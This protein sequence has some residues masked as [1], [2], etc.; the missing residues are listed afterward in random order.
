MICLIISIT[1]ILNTHNYALVIFICL[2]MLGVLYI[3]IAIYINIYIYD[4]N[5]EYAILILL[6]GERKE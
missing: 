1:Y 3:N 5:I 2:M 6:K 4:S